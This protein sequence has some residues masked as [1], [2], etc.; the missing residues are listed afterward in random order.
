MLTR[1]FKWGESDLGEGWIPAWMDNA[2][3]TEGQGAA[4]DCLEHFPKCVGGFEGE[5]MALGAMH[6]T[7]DYV[8]ATRWQWNLYEAQSY[9]IAYFL[10]NVLDGEQTINDVP[11]RMDLDRYTWDLPFD[12]STMRDA[13]RKGIVSALREAVHGDFDRTMWSE[14]RALP[15]KVD[16]RILQWMAKGAIKAQKRFETLGVSPVQLGN[17]FESIARGFNEVGKG[18]EH[19]EE[20]VVYVD[21]QRSSV[22]I[23]RRWMQ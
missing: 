4:H 16:E 3:P 9:D 7:R 8:D 22:D 17:I 15:P 5:M 23:V 1:R 2:D 11:R 14:R 21:W 19:G 20:M 18:G 10:R 12:V 13:I 6:V